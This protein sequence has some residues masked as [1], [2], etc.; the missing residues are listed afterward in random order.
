MVQMSKRSR[1]AP[2]RMLTPY[3]SLPLQLRA[4]V[5]ALIIQWWAQLVESGELELTFGKGCVA[6]S[7]FFKLLTENDRLFL[8]DT[9]DKG[10]CL[11][12]LVSPIMNAAFLTL[13]VAPHL[14]AS[15]EALLTIEDAYGRI[16]EGYPVILGLTKQEKLL[17]VHQHFG[18]ATLGKVPL[19]FDGED[20]WVEVLTKADFEK[21]QTW[22]DGPHKAAPAK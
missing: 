16:F 18:Y 3:Q 14:R 12:F 10:I 7:Q 1:K 15:R 22:V 6:I 13:W 19:I 20:A 17:K 5:D 4:G 11:A 2:E 8:Y 9:D 21:R